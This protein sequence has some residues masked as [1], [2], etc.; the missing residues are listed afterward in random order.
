MGWKMAGEKGADESP[1]AMAP[2]T[3]KKG[4]KDEHKRKRKLPVVVAVLVVI[5]I[6]SRIGSCMRSNGAETIGWPRSGLA[7][8]I[9]SPPTSRGH[10]YTDSDDEFHVIVKGCSQ[11][12]YYDYVES[13]KTKGFSVDAKTG[14]GEY[15]AFSQSGEKLKLS[16]YT[17]SKELSITV[18]ATLVTSE[19]VWPTS[20]PGSLVPAPN[21]RDGRVTSDNSTRYAVTMADMDETA[22]RSYVES[23]IACGFNV[24]YKRGDTN[25]SASNAD[26]ATLVV[27]KLGFNRVSITIDVSEA[28]TATTDGAPAETA[29]EVS[30][31]A[32]QG[33]SSSSD[34]RAAIDAYESF[35]NDYCDFMEEYQA[36]GR[37][38]SML[39]KYGEMMGKYADMAAKFDAIDEGSLSA[40]DDAYYIQVQTRVNQR[41][42]AVA[43]R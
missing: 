39:A 33:G 25:F 10:I 16:Y 41:L 31:E 38:A 19:I 34:A 7:T 12:Q 3:K 28:K 42:L 5:F 23:C 8:T 20:G 21:S 37:P 22:Y 4:D 11:G 40:D 24:D 32:D 2:A 30:P 6:I 18:S 14:T 1:D 35:M 27:K 15:E 43:A 17:S 9:P 26:G 29:A 36:E 13:C